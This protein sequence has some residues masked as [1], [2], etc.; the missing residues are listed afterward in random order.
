MLV[1]DFVLY[2]RPP[3][4]SHYLKKLLCSF[5]GWLHF[6]WHALLSKYHKINKKNPR[7]RIFKTGL[8]SWRMT[9]SITWGENKI[10]NIS[11]HLSTFG[12]YREITHHT[13]QYPVS[14]IYILFRCLRSSFLNKNSS[15]EA[16]SFWE[17]IFY[18]ST[19]FYADII[20]VE[21]F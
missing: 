1:L 9:P 11:V 13:I 8:W 17:K 21:T 5:I 3:I 15:C 2:F 4:L 6:L 16:K 7:H 14:S 12:S 18:A 20:F 10:Q 19:K